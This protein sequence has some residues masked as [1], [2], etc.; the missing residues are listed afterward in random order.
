MPAQCCCT[1]L[2]KRYVIVTLCA[3]AMCIAHAMRVN[4]AVTVVTILDTAAPAKVG[5]VEAI[6]NV[7]VLYIF[8]LL[9]FSCVIWLG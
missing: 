6:I 8:L 3:L 2:P 1:C 7:S 4:V 5:T 9:T